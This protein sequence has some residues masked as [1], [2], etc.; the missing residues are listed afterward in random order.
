MFCTCGHE[1]QIQASV[2]GTGYA[3]DAEG[4]TFCYPCADE[5][6]RA[7]E[8]AGHPQAAPA[9]ESIR[10]GRKHDPSIANDVD[11]GPPHQPRR[12]AAAP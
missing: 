1:V 12:Q 7:R 2:G 3:S 8:P 5:R 6:D 9:D 11:D 4:R 10:R